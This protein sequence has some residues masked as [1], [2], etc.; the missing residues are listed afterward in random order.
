M[1]WLDLVHTP[2]RQSIVEAAERLGAVV[3]RSCW[4][5]SGAFAE[6]SVFLSAGVHVWVVL[7]LIAFPG[8]DQGSERAE[9]RARLVDASGIISYAGQAYRVGRQ[10]ARTSVQVGV[11]NS[12]VEITLDGRT[13]ATH[14]ILHDRTKE[15]GALANPTGRPRKPKIV[16]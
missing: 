3:G 9:V 7:T 13:I 4:R 1:E 8:T 15:H 10:H 14:P 12:Q 16:A 5:E 11:V 6:P 2:C